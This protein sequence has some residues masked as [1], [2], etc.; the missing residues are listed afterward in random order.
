MPPKLNTK[1][2]RS[3]VESF[4]CKLIGEYY[5]SDKDIV[6]ECPCGNQWVT[7]FHNFNKENHSHLCPDCSWKNFGKKRTIDNDI[8]NI[9]TNYFSV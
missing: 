8:E 5:G 9:L 7:H 1:Y 3:V 2:V 6:I 4:G